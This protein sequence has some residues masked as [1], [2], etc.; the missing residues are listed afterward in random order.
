VSS[1]VFLNDSRWIKELRP[2]C[3]RGAAYLFSAEPMSALGH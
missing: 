3:D 2:K 1:K